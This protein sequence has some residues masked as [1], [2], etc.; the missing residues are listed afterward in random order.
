MKF[1]ALAL[2]ILAESAS[3][4]Y[5]R[6][7]GLMVQKFGDYFADDLS[8]FN[9]NPAGE[10]HGYDMV[11]GSDLDAEDYY[12]MVSVKRDGCHDCIQ[13]L[14]FLRPRLL[15][16]CCNRLLRATLKCPLAQT[17]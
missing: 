12:T 15:C 16:H 14:K 8:Y 10:F 3:A 1:L 13:V 5:Y 11:I 2:A 17:R 7:N 6:N 4:R 9:G